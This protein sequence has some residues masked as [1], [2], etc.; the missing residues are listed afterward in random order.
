M[1]IH[2]YKQSRA[3]MARSRNGQID[4]I[5]KLTGEKADIQHDI[6]RAKRYGEE[7]LIRVLQGDL[8]G[9][10]TRISGATSKV[11]R[12]E[13]CLIDCSKRIRILKGP[14]PDKGKANK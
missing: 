14:K 7:D 10:S 1:S 2:G 13:K 8:K 11:A 3:N 6:K 5:D 4:Y 9:V 12:L